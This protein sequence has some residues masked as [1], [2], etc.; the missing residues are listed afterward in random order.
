MLEAARL[1]AMMLWQAVRLPMD[2][3]RVV[4]GYGGISSRQVT[5]RKIGVSQ[6]ETMGTPFGGNWY[7]RS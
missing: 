3:V 5:S 4:R 7:K 6:A 1:A 2:S